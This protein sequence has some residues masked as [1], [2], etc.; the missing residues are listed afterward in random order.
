MIR[1]T[2]DVVV[3]VRSLS[4]PVAKAKHL[5][6]QDQSGVRYTA[7][8]SSRTPTGLASILVKKRFM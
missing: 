5:A 6:D 3:M 1:N 2:P 7:T 4:L 8:P